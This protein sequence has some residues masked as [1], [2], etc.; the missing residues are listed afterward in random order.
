[1]A[2]AF[3]EIDSAAITANTSTLSQLARGAEVC[4][5]VKANGY[6]HGAETAAR[7]ALAGGATRLGVAHVSEGL[8]LREAGFD[9]PIW[10]F[11]EPEPQEFQKCVQFHLEPPVYSERGIEALKSV[12]GSLEVHLMIDTGMHRVGLEPTEAVSVA[13]QIRSIPQAAIGSIWTHLAVADEPANPYTDQQLDIFDQALADLDSAGIEIPLTHAANSAGTIAVPRSHRDVVRPGVALYGLP[14]SPE[15]AGMVPLQPA[16]KLWSRVGLVKRHRAGERI[17]YG[18]RTRFAVDTTVAT[19]PIGYADGVRRGWWE[20]GSVLIHG[21]RCKIVGVITMDQMMVDVGSLDV[22]AGD[23]AVL[24][25]C[26]G[27]AEISATEWA[28]ALDTINYEIT[29][30]IGPRVDRI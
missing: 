23:E 8:A 1:M 3:A 26:Q 25:G 30:G 18:L 28:A 7:A 15:L 5:V 29:C 24:I 11:S 2:R 16:M 22:V 4:A 6:G 12:A 19:L 10:L 13:T 21:Q 17:S 20:Q 9:V 27:D 14:P